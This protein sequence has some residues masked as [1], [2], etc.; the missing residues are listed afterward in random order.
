MGILRFLRVLAGFGR[1]LFERLSL[2]G[3]SKHLLNMQYR[4]HPCISFFPNS[5]FYSNMILDAPNVMKDYER[6]LLTRPMF[7]PYSFINI[8]NGVE[9]REDDGR[10]LRNMV[11]VAV[12]IKILRNL[13]K[14]W[15]VSKQR[16]SIGIISPYAAQ[17]SA[18]QDKLPS[19]YEDLDGLIVKV[20]SIDGF[21]GGEE[22]IIMIS[23]VRSNASGN[24]G[25]MSSHQRTNVA[26]TR[27][28]HCLWILGCG[29]TLE[30]SDTIWASLVHDAKKRQCFINADE[31]KDLE[32][33]I[34]D[35]K[36]QLNQWN[37]LLNDDSIYFKDAQWKV[38]FSENFKKSFFKLSSI[39]KK[40]SVLTLLLNLSSGW[41]PKNR[42]V[43]LICQN[44]SHI[45]KRFKTEGLFLVCTIDI[46]KEDMYTQVLKIWDVLASDEVPKLVKRLEGLFAMYTDEYISHCKEKFIQGNLEFP[47]SWPRT[48]NIIQYKTLCH[49]EAGT[50]TNNNNLI[51]SNNYVE[52]SKV[53]ESLMLMKFYSLSSGVMS[54]LLSDQEG[55]ELELPFE[56]TDQERELILFPQSTFILG[57]SG[58]GKTT[59]LTMKLYEKEQRHQIAST[60][61]GAFNINATFNAIERNEVGETSRP[62]NE[63]VLRQL[64]VTVSPKLCFAIKQ[65][66][67]G[68]KRFACGGSFSVDEKS[69]DPDDN[70]WF[71]DI[72]DS[73]IDIPHQTYPLVITF[74]KFLM[75]LDGTSGN[76]FFERFVGVSELY[77]KTMNSRSIA[78]QTFIR[79]KEVNYDRFNSLYWP[80]FNSNLKKKFDPSKVF[81]EIISCI[82]GGLQAGQTYSGKLDLEEYKA[83]S[84]GRTSTL[85]KQRRQDIYEIFQDYEKMKMENGDFDLADLVIDLHDRLRKERFQ[86]DEIDFVYIDE[87]QDLSMQQIALFKYV[88]KNVE[89]GFV[90]SG[91]TAQTI[92]RGIDFRFEDIRCLFYK[93]FINESRGGDIVSGRKDIKGQMSDIFNLNQN[94][95]THD[96]VLRLAQS[97]IDLIYNFFPQSIDFLN[98]ERSLIYGES[99]V[100]LESG[101]DE[102]AIVT[103]FGSSGS[104]SSNIIGFGA[105]QVILVRDD[106]AREEIS[107]YVGKHALVLTITECKGLEFQDVLL[108]NFFGSSPLNNWRV[109]YEFMKLREL[110]D[111]KCMSFPSFDTT[112]HGILCS[113]LKQLYVAITRTRQRLW[114]CENKEELSKPMF[115]YWKKLCLV[116]VR[117]LDDSLAK[118]MQVASCPEEW[119]Q[120]G[121]KLFYESNYEMATMCFERAGDLT[122]ESRAKA[123]GLKAAANRLR[124]SNDELAFTILREAA[125]IFESIGR[126]EFAEC[127]FELGEYEKAGRIYLD[128][129]GKPELR[130]AGECFFLAG[131]SDLAA[132]VYARGGFLAEC[133]SVCTKGKLYDM[134]LQYIEYW[135]QHDLTD[136]SVVKTSNR[137]VE[138]EQKF[139]QSCAKNY[140]ELEDRVSMMKFV[141]AFQSIDAKRELLSS[142]DCLDELLLV[143]QESG[144]F[145]EAA[146]IAKM[147]GDLLLES[148][149]LGKAGCSNEAARLLI[150]SV[151][152]TS[153]WAHGSTGW[154]LKSFATKDDLLEKAISF[155]RTDPNFYKMIYT[156][157]MILSSEKA[158]LSDLILY[159][160]ASV[161][162]GS[163][164]GE[165]LSI[166]RILDLHLCVNGSKYELEDELVDDPFSHSQ[167]VVSCN[168]VSVASLLFYWNLWAKMIDKIISFL[169]SSK[170]LDLDENNGYVL[171]CF[172][173]FGVRKQLNNVN[174]STYHLLNSEAY[175]VKKIDKRFLRKKGNLLYTDRSDFSTVALGHW[176]SELLFVGLKV[177][178][179][180]EVI[181]GRI[182]PSLFCRTM[183]LLHMYMIAKFLNS[184]DLGKH[185]DLQRLQYFLRKS[186]Q[187]F[188][189]VFP[190]DWN[191]TLN[192]N[193]VFLRRTDDFRSLLHESLLEG[194]LSK[195]GLTHGKIGRIMALYL[196]SGRP[197]D[198]MVMKIAERLNYHSSWK[199]FFEDSDQDIVTRISQNQSI[200]VKISS[201]YKLMTAL[202]ETYG[203]NWRVPDYISPIC[204]LYILERLLLLTSRSQKF[205]YTTKS[206]FVEWLI[207]EKPGENLTINPK[208]DAL[209]EIFS[210][211]EYLIR[212]L[213][214]DHETEQW[215]RKSGVNIVNFYPIMVLRCV[216]MSCLLYLNT[217]NDM[218]NQILRQKHITSRL[219]ANFYT[220]LRTRNTRLN[221]DV[222]SDALAMIGNPLVIVSWQDR[223][224]VTVSPSAILLEPRDGMNRE[225]ILSLLFP[226]K[227]PPSESVEHEE[228]QVKN[229]DSLSL[230]EPTEISALFQEISFALRSVDDT[231]DK[232]FDRF[233]SHLPHIQ[234]ELE[235]VIMLI[236]SS[237]KQTSIGEDEGLLLEVNHIFEDLKPHLNYALETRELGESVPMI[238]ELVRKLNMQKSILEM[239]F[240]KPPR[241]EGEE[242]R[243]KDGESVNKEA[244]ATGSG[245]YEDDNEIAESTN[246]G[247]EVEVEES[248]GKLLQEKKLNVIKDKGKKKKNK[249]KKARGR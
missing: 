91:D 35:I 15:S 198:E 137:I 245:E 125:N 21:Q 50:S 165:I 87:V 120:R 144:N 166:R 221:A 201:A 225:S 33:T 25:F 244:E 129:C 16:L 147:R 171:F 118:A 159:L 11:E 28:R 188:Q 153:L 202:K 47:K 133:L 186:H 44:S 6:N 239:F 176:R 93:E 95:R 24:V 84:D 222:I 100:L 77:G 42:N 56:V 192:D 59:V 184:K 9:E 115:D 138:M 240:S 105:E 111:D 211:I 173:Y 79:N 17:V 83:L 94:F 226:Q 13:Y 178:E 230:S 199:I 169:E 92:A 161:R 67:S 164:R 60:G 126:S 206:V 90:F 154:P 52:N 139:L 49:Q 31:E 249:K 55:K 248:Q 68:L 121:I 131:R 233:I 48:F 66:V 170:K 175:W 134:G 237:R 212:Q 231:T 218:L 207:Y 174:A 141:R 65:H 219:P 4:M 205:L 242:S 72:S 190:L 107:C 234:V 58:T 71:T 163:L 39:R 179:T 204:F 45:L 36:K 22:D 101:S 88:C 26:L 143:E 149:L 32:K 224:P 76:S 241:Q 119:K 172:E 70:A 117:Q 228:D 106:D 122:W 69:E 97:V 41:R 43:D 1:S 247:E 114:I 210:Y 189:N 2:L 135:K 27:A 140:Y 187:H 74:N 127:L 193:I 232:S 145:L 7:G 5:K 38:L 34:L 102:N 64:F 196:S 191:Q 194:V 142:L 220:S 116:Q 8:R 162:N 148:D 124:G 99:P 152:L 128:K 177:L 40:Q 132:E 62:V 19:I 108:Y 195:G 157:A 155:A 103:I 150:W 238:L 89:E 82:K 80:R 53:S 243:I 235:K 227:K 181:S 110:L 217:G 229:V 112:R 146:V 214:Y 3:H 151:F 168:S 167:K 156:D 37:D 123:T 109:V 130:K 136:G 185:H 23:T 104:M 51:T 10:S 30:I 18:I 61:F 180:L 216:I 158:K 20:M 78:L 98:P 223:Y 182:S 14:A 236:S 46:K 209:H 85:T 81:T 73:F 200:I 213:L 183:P 208:E 63:T 96:G 54:H 215:I 203:A 57:R 12:V 75:M 246:N 113:E 197:T 86:G 29:R 160:H